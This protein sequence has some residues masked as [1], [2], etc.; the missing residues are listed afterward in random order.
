MA[1]LTDDDALV[2]EDDTETVPEVGGEGV[3]PVWGLP[4]V[5]DPTMQPGTAL[6]GYKTESLHFQ[7]AL[8]RATPDEAFAAAD[9]FVKAVM[10]DVERFTLARQ[11]ELVGLRADYLEALAAYYKDR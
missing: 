11:L 6:I 5:V 3:G 1:E 4:V 8:L 7:P 2:L 9:R 10:G